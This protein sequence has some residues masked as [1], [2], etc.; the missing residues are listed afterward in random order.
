MTDVVGRDGP[1]GRFPALRHRNFRRYIVGQGVSLIGFWMQSVAVGWLVYRLSGSEFQLGLVSFIAYLPVLCLSPIAGAMADRVDKYRLILVTQTTLMF[2]ALVLGT[3]SALHLATV[4]VVAVA[5]ACMGMAGAF[6]LPAR[7][8]FLVDLVGPE[9]LPSAIALNATIFNAARVVG[10]AVAGMMVGQ[11]GEAPCFFVNGLSYLAALW[12]LLGMRQLPVRPHGAVRTDRSLRSGIAYVR[13]Q[14]M[15]RALL[16]ALGFVSAL[17]LQANVLMPALAKR[18]FGA[19]AEGYGLLLTAY[20]AGAVL[21]AM[22]L[23]RRRHSLAEQRHVMLVGL[24]VFGLGLLGVAFSPTFEMAVLCQL[25]AGLGMVRFTATTN[26]SVQ[27]VVDDAYRGRV[28]GLHTLM[29]A[30]VAPLGSLILGAL[31]TPYG[32]QPA[33]VVSAAVPLLAA[34]WLRGVLTPAAAAEG[35]ATASPARE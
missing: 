33:L 20:G 14:P 18:S 17:S 5:A 32:P 10:P 15:T 12:A 30:G 28:M 23:A 34:L 26:A 24:V 6:D 21:S 31:A 1:G 35:A 29:F 8:S 19:D 2:L 11:V 3:L 7:Q 4:P 16:I 22:V 9:D 27:M 13:R 25:A